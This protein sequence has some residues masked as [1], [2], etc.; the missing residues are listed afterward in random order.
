MTLASCIIAWSKYIIAN[1]TLY[2]CLESHLLSLSHRHL[3]IYTFKPSTSITMSL[4]RRDVEFPTVDGIT[5][6][7]WF[8]PASDRNGPCVIMTPGVCLSRTQYSLHRPCFMADAML[9]LTLVHL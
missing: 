4:N 5:L 2:T 7:G 9:L 1:A 6:K 8:F 3:L